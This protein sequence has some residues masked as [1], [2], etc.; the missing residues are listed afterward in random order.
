MMALA[1]YPLGLGFVVLDPNEDP[2][3]AQVAPHIQGAFDDPSLLDA[4]AGRADVITYDLEHWPIAAAEA[5]RHRV[6]VY[7]PVEALAV[8]QDR[9]AEKR[10]FRHLGIPTP[11]FAPVASRP[12]LE[13]A[14][15]VVGLPAIL[16]TRFHGYDG[17]GQRRL[18][19]AADIPLA[20]EALGGVPLI[21]EAMVPFD[22]EV[23]CIAVAGGGGE[24]RFYPVTANRHRNGILHAS[25]AP[26]EDPAPEAEALTWTAQLL[27]HWAYVGV[28]TVE[29]FVCNGRL[30]ANEVA[31]RVHNSGHW[32]LE[33]AATSQF[34][35]H[36]RAI[37]GWP[38]GS[39]AG[40]GG[41]AMVNLIG[42]A[43]RVEGL[44]AID[45]HLHLYGKAPR[46][47]RKLGHLTALARPGQT[48]E[49]LLA[50]LE[51]QL[52]R[53]DLETP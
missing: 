34:E 8:A 48:P 47:L 33:G 24:R 23:S 42:R 53:V 32:T 45:G 36:L 49:V 38:L 22:G 29:Y 9:L 10:L 25:T 5:L 19:A 26:L 21:L 4:L 15:A 16:K 30:L 50:H 44:L 40:L 31:P 17:K 41:C 51:Q 3:A 52:A 43:P 2:C 27:D 12:E 20:W 7:P 37:M 14:V 18:H 35:N 13:A 11:T 46:P 28:L 6:P 39:T 1:G